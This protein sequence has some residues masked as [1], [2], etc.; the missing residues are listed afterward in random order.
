MFNAATNHS[1]WSVKLKRLGVISLLSVIVL[2]V[3]H[4]S[5]PPPAAK[6]VRETD[7]YRGLWDQEHRFL[8]MRP[9]LTWG[10]DPFIKKPGFGP[11]EVEET[12]WDL[13]AIVYDGPE[14][15]A[16]INGKRVHMGD[17]I[18]GRLVDEIGQNFVLLTRGDSVLELNLPASTEAGS[19]IRIEEDEPQEKDEAR[20]QKK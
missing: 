1:H 8:F 12:K 7:P 13:V 4:S 5:E 19:S 20:G 10:R 17:E 16:I 11:S 9:E 3:A 18:G 6:Q 2:T 14:S 15:E